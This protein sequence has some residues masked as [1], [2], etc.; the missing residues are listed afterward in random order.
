VRNRRATAAPA[1][2]DS[3]YNAAMDRH[4]RGR[5]LTIVGWAILGA[6][7]LGL[8]AA[9]AVLVYLGTIDVHFA[10]D[11]TGPREV[12]ANVTADTEQPLAILALLLGTAAG[13][14]LGVRRARRLEDGG[15]ADRALGGR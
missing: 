9:I 1:R 12:S 4:R 15:D 13:A 3:A 2:G 5:A 8:P 10:W 11:D 14:A 6:L 7:L